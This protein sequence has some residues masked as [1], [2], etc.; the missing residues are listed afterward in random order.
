ML[1]FAETLPL[2]PDGAPYPTWTAWA[3]SLPQTSA[4]GISIRS[5]TPGQAEIVVEQSEWPLNPSGGVHGGLVLACADHCFGIVLLP[6]LPAGLAPATIAF[7]SQFL[8][9]AIPPLTFNARVDRCGR[10]VASVT[11]EVRGAHGRMVARANGTL[12]VNGSTPRL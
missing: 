2:D 1:T 10:T 6:V 11:V 4:S 3:E 8:E 9:P 5:L 12:S 7:T